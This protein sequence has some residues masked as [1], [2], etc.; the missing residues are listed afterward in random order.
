MVNP[1]AV[2]IVI[3]GNR[4]NPEQFGNYS[5]FIFFDGLL[6]LHYDETQLK[7][8]AL[9]SDNLANHTSWKGEGDI[10]V[11]DLRKL[12]QVIDSVHHLKR[13]IRFWNAPDTLPTWQLFKNWNIDIINTDHIQELESF[14]SK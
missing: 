2:K 10:P 5:E 13:P 12:T 9:F 4:P 3:S 1:N 6:N 11:N 8:L 7:H 14:L